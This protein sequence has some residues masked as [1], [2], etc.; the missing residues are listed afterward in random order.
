MFK[1][2]FKSNMLWDNRCLKMISP[3]M[4]EKIFG[5]LYFINRYY[6]LKFGG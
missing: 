1:I 4:S 6:I 2:V 3:R 5:V